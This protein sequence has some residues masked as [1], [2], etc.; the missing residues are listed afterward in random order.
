MQL[1]VLSNISCR[2]GPKRCTSKGNG[3]Q[4]YRGCKG[5]QFNIANSWQVFSLKTWKFNL[6]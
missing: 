3:V 4:Y 6:M 1:V 2:E 5:Q